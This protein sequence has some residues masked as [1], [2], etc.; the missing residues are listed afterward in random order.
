MRSLTFA[1]TLALSPLA[2]QAD[3]VDDILD[4]QILPAMTILA[5]SSQ[6]L[7]QA[8]AVDCQITSPDLRQAYIQA[9]DAWVMVSHLRFGPTETDNRAFALAFWPDSRGKIPKTLVAM[10]KSEDSNVANAVD[11][12]TSSIAVRG[13]Y[14]L[15][16]LLYDAEL[17]HFGKPSYRCQ[18][19]RAMT[20]DIATTAQDILDEWQSSYAAQMRSPSGRYQT[21]DEVKQELF[22]ALNTGLQITA[23]MRLGRPLGSFDHPRPNRAEARRSGRSLHHVELSLR[24]LEPLAVALA[25]DNPDLAEDLHNGFAKALASVARLDDPV[26][27]GVAAPRSRFRIEA[28]QQQINDLRTRAETDLGP[29]LGVEPGFNSLDGD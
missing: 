25:G 28:L 9:F 2:A 6:T 15:E 29:A 10:I 12:A 20:K 23:D 16:F 7:S 17:S 4:Q 21:K 3:M 8:A 14:A 11:F 1:L 18:L 27:A 5:S 13:F 26:F 24:T 19:V 22:K